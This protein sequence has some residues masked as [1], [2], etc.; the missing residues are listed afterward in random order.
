[1]AAPDGTLK[2]TVAKTMRLSSAPL[3]RHS[4]GV[5]SWLAP[6]MSCFMPK[7]TT[8]NFNAKYVEQNAL[9]SVVK[10]P[11]DSFERDERDEV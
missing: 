4:A 8:S 2:S 10:N 3:M 11:H 5:G 9:F 7:D 1:M 6:T